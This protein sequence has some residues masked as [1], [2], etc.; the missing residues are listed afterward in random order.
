MD[1]TELSG[2]C[3]DR[4]GGALETDPPRSHT[5]SNV[6]RGRLKTGPHSTVTTSIASLDII[7]KKI[8]KPK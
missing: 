8:Q 2:L 5:L 6:K 4:G 3:Q 1:S 7:L